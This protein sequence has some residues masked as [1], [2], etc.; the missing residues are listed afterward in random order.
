MVAAQ[1]DLFI[2]LRVLRNMNAMF[3]QTAEISYWH[4]HD[5]TASVWV[6]VQVQ[7]QLDSSP[8][9][10]TSF[11]KYATSKSTS[12]A[13]PFFYAKMAADIT[14]CRFTEYEEQKQSP[15]FS[16]LPSE[17]RREIFAYALTSAP[18]ATG[19]TSAQSAD[20]D[21]CVARPGYEAGH[22]IWT[23]LLRTCKRVYME[24]WLMPFTCSE[25]A[26]Y[27]IRDRV[28]MTREERSPRRKMSMEQLQQCL[29]RI[30]ARQG[31]VRGGH[32]R[33]FAQPDYLEDSRDFARLFAMRHFHPKTV[34]ITVRYIDT[35]DWENNRPLQI[36]GRWSRSLILPASVSS[37]TLEVESLER[38]NDEV[39]YIAEELARTWHF[40]RT[41]DVNLL[42]DPSEISVSRWTGSSVLGT[43][44]W[45]RDETRPGQLDYYI[46][47][48]TW[49][50]SQDPPG[51]LPEENPW[52]IVK[53]KRRM[54]R[55]LGYDFIDNDDLLALGITPETP[56][57]KAV[58]AYAAATV[59]E[60]SLVVV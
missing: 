23:E 37:F 44:R 29:D 58:A 40:R 46:A 35:F 33:L 1:L 16:L 2:E 22:R 55:N 10:D 56:A 52:L 25:H 53:G 48:V 14:P 45:V 42:A 30:N 41:D 19:T 31:E 26:F 38:R 13:V 59:Q 3:Q 27:I 18:E 17:I 9:R 24:A 47:K 8:P 36:E 4:H 43:Q 20:Q 12:I 7:V 6:Q 49:R 50:P 54:P 32:I 60:R 57:E 51:S 5:S 34:T 39:D 15:L 28:Y 11:I 21:A